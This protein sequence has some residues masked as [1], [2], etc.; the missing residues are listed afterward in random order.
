MLDDRG[1]L[2]EWVLPNATSSEVT[3][4]ESFP[5]ERQRMR[6]GDGRRATSSPSAERS[7]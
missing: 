1:D 2:T 6:L 3:L 7:D 5:S 4:I